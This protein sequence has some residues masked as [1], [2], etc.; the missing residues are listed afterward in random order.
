MARPRIPP[1][2]PPP[3]RPRTEATGP[4]GLVVCAWATLAL[5]TLYGAPDLRAYL[6]HDPALAAHSGAVVT[7]LDTMAEASGA[8]S[9]RSSIEQLTSRFARP[10]VV[11]K[12]APEEAP[13][14][15]S[16]ARPSEISPLPVADGQAASEPA[17]P[18]R[19]LLV[20]ASSIQYYVGAELE[21][22]LES[23]QGV[24]VRRVG[25]LSTGLARP[26]VFDWVAELRRLVGE[27][28]PDLVIG[29]FGG[30]DTQNLVL[31]DGQVLTFGTE[32]WKRAYRKRVR[33]LVEWLRSTG[34][35]AVMLGMPSMRSARYARK[36]SRVN[37]ATRE[38]TEAAGGVYVDTWDISADPNGQYRRTVT[39]RGETGL[40]RLPDGI[41]Y[42]RLGARFV[43]ERIAHRLETRFSFTPADPSLATVTRH[44]VSSRL[45]GKPVPYLAFVP[46]EL[47]AGE[48]LPV[49]YLLHGA[50][51]SFAEWSERAH[52]LLQRLSTSHRL[53]LVAPDGDAHGWWVDSTRVAGSRIESFIVKELLPDVERR[54]PVSGKRGVLGISMGGNGA[55]ALALRHPGTFHV[56][57]SMS[58]A[59]DLTE[60]RT[61]SALIE[62]L[63]AFEENPAAW[64]AYSAL[65]LVRARPEVARD[66]PIRLTVGRAD[67]WVRANRALRG[68]LEAVGARPLH[69]E[70]E[71][72][73]SWSHWL[74]VLPVHIAW[75]GEQLHG[76]AKTGPA[77]SH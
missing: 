74:S 43:S 56:V 42:S 59:V 76:N 52:E 63:G 75:Q 41:H 6:L 40:M 26:D 5:L 20:G 35:Q 34:A 33:E 15:A 25:R 53:I 66:L 23:Y 8:L 11:L 55:L 67:R 70:S 24:V 44:E 39:H 72:G 16:V 17:G 46:Q 10:L 14:V 62:R 7:R 65:H 49:L 50:S 69:E 12:R 28:R 13:A 3:A 32:P 57:G 54:L 48:R 22:L 45:R 38:A 1:Q 73:H 60:A 27:F 61:R 51:S 9:V 58:G 4:A 37:A 29:M 19:V 30:N 71:G 21:R 68:A 64:R 2:Q 18:K 36:I 77:V 47:R 31:D